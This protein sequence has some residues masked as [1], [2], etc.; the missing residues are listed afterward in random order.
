MELDTET[1]ED[2][3]LSP[4][5][6]S[7][8]ETLKEAA[9]EGKEAQASSPEGALQGSE[10]EE[11]AEREDLKESE[12]GQEAKEKE[13]LSSPA[14]ES[15]SSDS[16]DQ[17][18]L[19]DPEAVKEEPQ[20]ETESSSPLPVSEDLPEDDFSGSL[21]A[22][23]SADN[24]LYALVLEG[25][26]VTNELMTIQIGLLAVLF[27]MLIFRFVYHLVSRIVTKF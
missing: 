12:S 5:N 22:D 14:S 21:P 7:D 4:E 17:E 15:A 13:F 25:F 24:D 8:S 1:L 18:K 27:S 20:K 3:S 11:D 10:S 6:D 19:S 16:D 26:Q 2:S 23:A 9:P